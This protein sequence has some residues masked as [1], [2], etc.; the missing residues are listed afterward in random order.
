MKNV[1]EI[2]ELLNKACAERAKN[3]AA[4]PPATNPI[5]SKMTKFVNERLGKGFDVNELF[6]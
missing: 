6:R 2:T 1:I 5:Y 3:P 4:I